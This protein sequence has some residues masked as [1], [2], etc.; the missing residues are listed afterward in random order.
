MGTWII[1][2]ILLILAVL[3][4]RNIIKTRKAGA[5]PDAREAV[6]ADAPV[7]PTLQI[8]QTIPTNFL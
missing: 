5:V 3:A 7:V 8:T 2:S 4:I 1:A 6:A